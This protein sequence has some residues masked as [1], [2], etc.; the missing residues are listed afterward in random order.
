MRLDS[1][2]LFNY[3]NF[4]KQD[5]KLDR[6]TNLFIGENAQ[7]KTNSIAIIFRLA[8]TKSFRT[9]R[10]LDMVKWGETDAQVFGKFGANEVKVVII[11]E[12]KKLYINKHS[13]KQSYFF[14]RARF[15]DSC[16]STLSR[17]CNDFSHYNG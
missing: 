13:D 9:N 4:S 8:T 6:G 17:K 11:P 1:V 10:D 7:G 14:R 2:T 5:I 16:N 15:G 3:R 12:N